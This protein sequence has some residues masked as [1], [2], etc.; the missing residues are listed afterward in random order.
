MRNE[1]C[2]AREDFLVKNSHL[3]LFLLIIQLAINGY[4]PLPRKYDA[5]DDL[6]SADDP[7]PACRGGHRLSSPEW[8]VR[9]LNHGNRASFK[10]ICLHKT[11]NL[12]HISKIGHEKAL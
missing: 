3:L 7:Y 8:T 12:G 11:G 9:M 4:R 6:A 10:K 2:Y 5:L 1:V